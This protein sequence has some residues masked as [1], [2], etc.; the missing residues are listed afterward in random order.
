MQTFLT[1]SKQKHPTTHFFFTQQAKNEEEL[2]WSKYTV[3]FLVN[4]LSRTNG[5]VCAK[6][7]SDF[8]VLERVDTSL[9]KYR[10]RFFKKWERNETTAGSNAEGNSTNESKGM[11]KWTNLQMQN[12]PW[13]KQS[14]CVSCLAKSFLKKQNSI[15]RTQFLPF[16]HFREGVYQESPTSS[17]L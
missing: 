11:R 3:P 9:S 17:S 13:N 2:H 5:M 8:L 15:P 16:Y 6:G 12:G 4:H 1:A 7:V 14:F 10:C